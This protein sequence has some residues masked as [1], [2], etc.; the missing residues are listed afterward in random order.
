MGE[1]SKRKHSASLQSDI[2]LSSFDRVDEIH[3]NSSSERRLGPSLPSNKMAY[4]SDD[5]RL[6]PQHTDRSTNRYYFRL[7]TNVQSGNPEKTK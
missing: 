5:G 6:M 2:L 3:M 4:P 7:V 1:R